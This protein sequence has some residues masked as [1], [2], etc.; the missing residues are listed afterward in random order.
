MLKTGKNKNLRERD[1]RIFTSYSPSP[2]DDNWTGVDTHQ[3]ARAGGSQTRSV[4]TDQITPGRWGRD[5]FHESIKQ[6]ELRMFVV[7][8]KVKKKKSFLLRNDA[9]RRWVS[10]GDLV[11][12]CAGQVHTRGKGIPWQCFNGKGVDTRGKGGILK[13]VKIGCQLCSIHERTE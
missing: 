7:K 12:Q 5:G 2:V 8:G 4:S 11:P 3:Q 9:F 13:R 1:R 6:Q 10:Q